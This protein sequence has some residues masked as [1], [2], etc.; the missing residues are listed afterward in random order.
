MKLMPLSSAASIMRM[1]SSWSVLPHSPNIIAPRQY[2]VTWIP[3]RPI[4]RYF[5]AGSLSRLELFGQRRKP[6]PMSYAW[7]PEEFEGEDA[8]DVDASVDEDLLALH[9][10]RHL[11]DELTP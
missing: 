7:S 9:A 4:E 1:H 11:F 6:D 10:D 3:V 8:I 2:G 5:M